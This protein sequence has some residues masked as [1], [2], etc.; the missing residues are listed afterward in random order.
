LVQLAESAIAV[1][2][3]TNDTIDQAAATL[4]DVRSE[5]PND[6][7]LSRLVRDL[8]S[9]VSSEAS[10]ASRQGSDAAGL[11]MLEKALGHFS[12][13]PVLVATQ[14]DI[15]QT[16]RQREEEQRRQIAA[17]SGQLAIDAMPWGVVK[18]IRSQDGNLVP[19]NGETQTP[20]VQ[21]LLEGSY[22]VLVRSDSGV[23]STQQVNVVRQQLVLIRADYD[24]IS[25]DEYFEK[26][27]W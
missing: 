8:T 11:L 10:S 2:P 6:A 4:A 18:E 20:F 19:L 22:T 25:A 14:A 13:N 7:S 15:R 23:E 5:F 17:I 16:Q 24:L 26:S 3:M 21:T 12:G 27:G 1:R 9:A